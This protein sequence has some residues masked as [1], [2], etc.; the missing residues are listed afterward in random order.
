MVS[1]TRRAAAVPVVVL[2][3]TGALLF[4]APAR[5]ADVY[6]QLTP[7]TVEA[8]YLVGIRASCR[9]NWHPATV[10]SEAFGSVTVHPQDGFLTGTATVPAQTR[11]GTYRVKLHCPEGPSAS[12]ML[13]VTA[14][15]HSPHPQPP[16]RP[17]PS[18]G[19]ATG[20]GGTAGGPDVGALLLPGGLGLTVAGLSLAMVATRRRSARAGPRR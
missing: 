8:G 1:V 4:A 13:T 10:E 19:P 15:R 6:V 17:N 5:A 3:A 2:A 20:F 16:P 9:S 14:A 18:R 11:S 7:S 12:T